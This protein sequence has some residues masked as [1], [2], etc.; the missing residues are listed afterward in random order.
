MEVISVPLTKG[1][2]ALIDACD[3]HMVLPFSWYLEETMGKKYARKWKS[4]SS[5]YEKMHRLILNAPPR[6]CVDHINGDGLDNR[7]HNLRLATRAQNSQN[8]CRA[9]RKGRYVG[10]SYDLA[11]GKY[12]MQVK[13]NGII[14]STRYNT[15]MEAAI[16]HDRVVKRVHGEFAILNFPDGD[17]HPEMQLLLPRS[18]RK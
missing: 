7:R 10:F 12:N 2:T 16:A 3:A 15:E 14:Y 4:P 9:K 1:H 18:L 17:P 8:F 13:A 6:L 11:R 5:L